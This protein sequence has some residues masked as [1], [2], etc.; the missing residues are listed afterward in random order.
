M[1][2]CSFLL[3]LFSLVG[4][5]PLSILL[6]DDQGVLPLLP[7]SCLSGGVEPDVLAESSKASNGRCTLEA[8]ELLKGPL[9]ASLFL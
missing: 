7:W 9:A 4:A 6:V 1:S 3:L 5:E 2:L 8:D